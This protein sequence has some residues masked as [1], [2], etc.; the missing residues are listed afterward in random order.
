ML[1]VAFSPVPARRLEWDDVHAVLA[2]EAS[3]LLHHS[4][5]AGPVC[6]IL[7]RAPAGA[8]AAEAA[9]DWQHS[10]MLEVLQVQAPM[11]AAH[12]VCTHALQ[13]AALLVLWQHR[14]CTVLAA[15]LRFVLYFLVIALGAAKICVL[16][17][18]SATPCPPIK[19]THPFRT[20]LDRVTN[21]GQGCRLLD[22]RQA[23]AAA[24]A[25]GSG[26]AAAAGVD[27]RG[28]PTYCLVVLQC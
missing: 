1:K 17:A 16:H 4:W 9:T 19:H 6:A 14:R 5:A 24:D 13:S 18:C 27:A 11:P 21:V 25:S 3:D 2:A 23:A 22:G 15:A 12:A 10:L 28:A 20:P 7:P 26:A 8:G